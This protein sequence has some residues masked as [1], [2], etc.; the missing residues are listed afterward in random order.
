MENLEQKIKELAKY[1]VN[2]EN[3]KNK[4]EY[5]A[6]MAMFRFLRKLQEDGQ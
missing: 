1:L 6:N 3:R 2:P 5:L 4:G